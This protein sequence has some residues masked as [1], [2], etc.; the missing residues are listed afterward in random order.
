MW[1]VL[2]N[3]QKMCY[4]WFGRTAEL[5]ANEKIKKDL[6][7]AHINIRAGAYISYAWF[8]TIFAA[9]ISTI[10][11]L[12]LIII[13]PLE[14]YLIFIFLLFPIS[15]TLMVYLYY[16]YKPA[17]KAK[18]RAKKI[19]LHL[20][21]ALNFISA[22]SSAGIT[23]TEIFKS[24]SKQRIY[25][26]IREEALWIFRDISLLGKDIISAIKANIDRTPS[27]KF[28]EFLQGAIVTVQSGGALKPYFMA[29]ADQYSREN[30]LVQKQ[31]I[32]SLG[33]MAEAYVTAAVSG[34][35]LIIIIIPLLMLIAKSDATQLTFM[36]F[37]IFI[38]IPLI[39]M[40]FA[41]VLSGMSTRV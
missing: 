41:V 4:R 11:Y 10:I 28:K 21:Y 6:E 19:D 14:F 37:F 30:R 34:V 22:M 24:L 9:I 27:E 8:N 23:P 18:S 12:S 16:K 29:K 32:E 20:P 2:N 1:M 40:G 5:M 3:Y 39:H 38:V 26:E 33:I 31:L 25:G 36:Y 13:L 7:K 17:M 35:L 15:L